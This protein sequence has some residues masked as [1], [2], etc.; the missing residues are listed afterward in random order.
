MPHR[1]F[2]QNSCCAGRMVRR[3]WRCC[4]GTRPPRQ[5][6]ARRRSRR[7][8][9][10]CRAAPLPAAMNSTP[11]RALD[12]G[13]APRPLWRQWE[14]PSRRPLVRR[15]RR[16]I[17]AQPAGSPLCMLACRAA[18]AAPAAACRRQLRCSRLHTR[19]KQRRMCSSMLRPE[20][21]VAL[22]RAC[23]RRPAMR[24][25]VWSLRAKDF[26]RP[27]KSCQ[28]GVASSSKWSTL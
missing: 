3:F 23:C 15:S 2:W 24:R 25:Q 5:G 14:K 9:R 11:C 6:A 1:E 21:A 12:L 28:H 20:A 17:L 19:N 16:P 4:T 26:T 18:C 10:A 7:R 13:S 27:S 8:P 22:K